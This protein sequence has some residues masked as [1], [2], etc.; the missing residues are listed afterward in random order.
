MEVV[1]EYLASMRE[2]KLLTGLGAAIRKRRTALKVSQEAFA[3][4]IAMHRAYYS[5]IE[6]GE[7][8]LTLGTLHRVAKGLGVRM[9]DL[10]RDCNA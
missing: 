1:D 6:R 5:A 8:N 3:D 2:E 7:R 10:L 4:L 9:A